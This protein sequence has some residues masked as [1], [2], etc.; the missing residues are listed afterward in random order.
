MFNVNHHAAS[1]WS[2]KQDTSW[3]D[4]D[5]LKGNN[6]VARK[7]VCMKSS[8]WS[9]HSLELILTFQCRLQ[10][11]YFFFR[12]TLHIQYV[13]N[14]WNE[15]SAEEHVQRKTV[16]HSPFSWLVRVIYEAFHVGKSFLSFRAFAATGRLRCPRRSRRWQGCKVWAGIHMSIQSLV[17][18][19]K[20]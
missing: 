16:G 14:V 2:G 10:F 4:C 5:A 13:M 7:E 8:T 18:L 20:H 9:N 15:I 6:V 3:P 1:F 17:L 12:L 11:I 19:F